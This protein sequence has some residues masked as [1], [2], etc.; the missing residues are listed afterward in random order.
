[1]NNRRWFLK[2]LAAEA[3]LSTA[4]SA[5][6]VKTSPRQA[7][8]PAASWVSS[9]ELVI[10]LMGDPQL[11]MTPETPA[12]VKAAMEDLAMIPHDFLAVLGDLAQNNAAYYAD[13]LDAVVAKST[14]PVFS[15]AGNGDLGAGL[16]AYREATGLPLYYRIYR[17]GIRFIFT[18]TISMTGKGRHICGLEAKQLAWLEKELAADRSATTIIFSHA[19]V[20][21]TTWHSEDRKDQ[22][23]P[24]S[25]YLKESAEMRALFAKYDNIKIFAH[26]H[27]HHGYGVKD[28]YGRGGYCR[29]GEVLHLSVGATANG[30]GSSFLYIGKKG[31]RVKVRDHAHHAWRD[32]FAYDYPVATTFVR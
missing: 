24:G 22:P 14:C 16:D 23:F 18:S 4:S 5:F 3:A 21:E 12:H 25:M 1:M 32:Q 26:G 11:I 31:I 15:L 29:E 28:Q 7:E 19:P 17:R 13:Y 10:A 20:F 30:Q 8:N 9:D 6:G 2:T 27:L